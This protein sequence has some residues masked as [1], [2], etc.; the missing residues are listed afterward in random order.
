MCRMDNPFEYRVAESLQDYEDC[1]T[2]VLEYLDTLG[3]DLGYMNLS[4]EFATMKQMYGRTEGLFILAF[5]EGKPVGCVGV[6]KLKTVLL[7]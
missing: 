7:N 6:R 3:I 2:I 5:N 1:K 4:D